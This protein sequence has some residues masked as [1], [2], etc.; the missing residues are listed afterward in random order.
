MHNQLYPNEFINSSLA[1]YG[2][3]VTLMKLGR[4]RMEIFMRFYS[5][6]AILNNGTNTNMII[7]LKIHAYPLAASYLGL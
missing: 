7:I 2:L 3:E 1:W 6:M 4:T 5:K